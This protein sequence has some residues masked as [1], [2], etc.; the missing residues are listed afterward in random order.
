MKYRTVCAVIGAMAYWGSKLLIHH[1]FLDVV[2][3][4]IGITGTLLL[5]QLFSWLVGLFI[6]LYVPETMG[7]PL[8]DVEKLLL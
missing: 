4:F 2:G 8:E 1:F 5:L 6:Y 3:Y 7:F